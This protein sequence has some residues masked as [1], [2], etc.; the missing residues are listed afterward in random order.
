MSLTDNINYL[1]PSKFQVVIDRRRF[2]NLNFFAQSFQHPNITTQ[3]AEVP[4]RQYSSSP[5]VPDSFSYGELSVQFIMDEDMRS[6]MEIHNW[7]KNNVENEFQS[8]DKDEP[9]YADIVI[10]ILSSKN[11]VNKKIKYRNAF[12][13]SIGEVPFEANVDGTTVITYPVSFRYT[14]FEI[15]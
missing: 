7:L 6:Y 15:E 3:A 12:P 10:T 4:Y 1:Q 13:V 14:Y 5:S 2:A 9:T 8:Q 11:N